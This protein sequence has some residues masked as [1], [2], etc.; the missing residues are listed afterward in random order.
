MPQVK[1]KQRIFN[2]NIKICECH[3][4]KWEGAAIHSQ[5]DGELK[6]VYYGNQNTCK[7]KQNDY[8]GLEQEIWRNIQ[9]G[10]GLSDT[11]SKREGNTDK[12]H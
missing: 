1:E 4:G 10:Q 6:G 12:E 5:L 8:E 3:V 7:E 11:G 9:E 2:R